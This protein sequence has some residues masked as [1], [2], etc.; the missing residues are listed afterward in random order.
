[1]RPA[2]KGLAGHVI[3]ALAK[4]YAAPEFA[5][6]EQVGNGTG[7]TANRWADA[8]AMSLWP[9]RGLDLY[10]F[11]IKVSRSDWLRELRNP[12]KAE[13][14]AA[15]CDFWFVAV[16]GPGILEFAEVPAPWGVLELNGRGLRQVKPAE[17]RVPAAELGRPMLAAILRRAS[18]GMVPASSIAARLEAAEKA[19]REDGQVLAARGDEQSKRDLAELRDAIAAFE[20]ESGVAI[21]TYGAGN[22]GKLFALA[23]G[24]NEIRAGWAVRAAENSLAAALKLVVNI[25]SGTEPMDGH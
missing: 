14:I 15:A 7:Y 18:E 3:A 21:G 9:S 23:R 22:I 20:R 25:R 5:L 8:V 16:G 6:F 17:R 24:L 11:E 4:R 13:D 1:M 2:A 10:G 12:A 19:G